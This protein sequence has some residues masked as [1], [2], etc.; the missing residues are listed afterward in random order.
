M[1]LGLVLRV[2]DN[3][4]AEK[5]RSKQESQWRGYISCFPAF[6]HA[7]VIL[8]FGA[9]DFFT[10]DDRWDHPNL[11][12]EEIVLTL[13]STYFLVDTYYGWVHKYN[14]ID[15][16]IHHIIS[17]ALSFC[18]IATGRCGFTILLT[19]T[20]GEVS[21]PFLLARLLAER[22]SHLTDVAYFSSLIFAAVF[23]IARIPIAFYYSEI[24]FFRNMGVFIRIILAGACELTRVPFA[25][26]GLHD[27]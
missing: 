9:F 10:C 5:D 18:A 8:A 25:G 4:K 16:H 1:I 23:L 21:N 13:S 19:F 17:I 15:M 6:I 20:L 22:H 3:I 11:A 7:L 24:V 27:H 2:P 14:G 26:L 12:Y